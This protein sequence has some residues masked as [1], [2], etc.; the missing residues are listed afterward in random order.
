MSSRIDIAWMIR[1]GRAKP[2]WYQR[3]VLYW[4]IGGEPA[5]SINYEADM[6]D[7]ENA[8]LRLSY[9]RGPEGD[10]ESVKQTVQLVYTEPH[11]GGRRWWMI[12]PYR[13]NRVGKLYLP[14]NG[15]RFAGRNAWRLGYH[16]QRV[17]RRD[18]PLEKLFRLQDKL[19]GERG[20]GAFVRRPKGMWHRTYERHL[21]RYWQLEDECSG[22]MMKWL[23]VLKGNLK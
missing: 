19:G 14:S 10:R 7:L 17:P 8:E 21:E 9:T 3:G 20:L 6:C 11:Y 1:T 5:G 22:E 15:D 23:A 18:R 4:T 13:H 16:C 12:C 2:E